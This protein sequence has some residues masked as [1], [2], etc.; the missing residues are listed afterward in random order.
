MKKW[1]EDSTLPCKAAL[2]MNSWNLEDQWEIDPNVLLHLMFR[3]TTYTLMNVGLNGSTVSPMGSCS[4]RRKLEAVRCLLK[5]F[6]P[7]LVELDFDFEWI[8]VGRFN[9]IKTSYIYL[10]KEAPLFGVPRWSHSN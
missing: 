2:L 8:Y 4:T 6:R 10:V 1:G 3:N 5:L 9:S 7:L